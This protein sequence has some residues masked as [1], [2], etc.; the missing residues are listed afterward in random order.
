MLSAAEAYFPTNR[1]SRSSSTD[2]S[3]KREHKN[4]N[5]LFHCLQLDYHTLL[6]RAYAV[7][8]SAR[9]ARRTPLMAPAIGNDRRAKFGDE[10]ETLSARIWSTESKS[11]LREDVGSKVSSR[12]Q[13]LYTPRSRSTEFFPPSSTHRAELLLTPEAENAPSDPSTLSRASVY[14]TLPS[15]RGTPR[16]CL[17]C[18]G[19]H[20]VCLPARKVNGGQLIL[21][22][23]KNFQARQ[24]EHQQWPSH[25]RGVQ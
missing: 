24:A 14:Y 9:A 5:F 2:Y 19:P 8:K 1:C 17:L 3:P 21:V 25:S 11:S 13:L 23:E 15:P 6:C 20:E 18:L 12:H 4:R 7:G 10:S 22:L 16:P